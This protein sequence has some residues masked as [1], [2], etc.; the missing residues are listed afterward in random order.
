MTVSQK[1]GFKKVMGLHQQLQ[2]GFHCKLFSF[3]KF[4]SLASESWVNEFNIEMV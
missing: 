1:K 2:Y 4:S 3:L